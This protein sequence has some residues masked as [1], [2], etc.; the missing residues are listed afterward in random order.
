MSYKQK[1]IGMIILALILVT[2]V[3]IEVVALYPRFLAVAA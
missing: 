2:A 3:I 1:C